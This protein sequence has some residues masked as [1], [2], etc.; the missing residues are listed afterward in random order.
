M[1]IAASVAPRFSDAMREELVK[2]LK[3]P[4]IQGVGAAHV[5]DIPGLSGTAVRTFIS[6]VLLVARPGAPHKVFGKI[7][8]GAAWLVPLL[9]NEG[10]PWT[11]AEIVAAAGAVSSP[12]TAK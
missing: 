7:S 4:K 10:Q 3:D 2:L 11:A 1:S 8:E 5:V 6:T 12:Q 9:S